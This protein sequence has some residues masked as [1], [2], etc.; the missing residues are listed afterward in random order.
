M[1]EDSS[2]P[3]KLRVL[4]ADDHP[5]VRAGLRGMLN[6]EPDIEVVAEVGSGPEAVT[7][8]ARTEIDVFLMD[9]RM[10]GGDGVTATA[11]IPATC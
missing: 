1:T 5:V 3:R 9:L 7:L 4:L 2:Q 8:A 6:T 11:A 10:P